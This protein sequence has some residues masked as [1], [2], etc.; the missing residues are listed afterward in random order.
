MGHLGRWL[1]ALVDDELDA[2]ERDRV[3]NHLAGCT[4]CRQ[5][6]NSLRALKR[7]M[8]S[9]SDAS[10]DSSITGRLIERARFDQEIFGTTTA[11]SARWPAS[12][13]RFT[14]GGSR[15]ISL[16]W[17][18]ATGS[19]GTA[20]VAIGVLAFLLGGAQTDPP[21]PKVTPAVDAY[22]LQHDYDTGQAPGARPEP[23]TQVQ[24][25]PT[26][27][28]SWAPALQVSHLL[29]PAAATPLVVA[30]AAA[31]PAAASPAAKAPAGTAPAGTAP[32][33]SPTAAAPSESPSPAPAPS[34]SRLSSPHSSP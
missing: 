20:L 33:A 34:T 17:R 28:G 26:G 15:Q 2:A 21:A 30:P 14:V 13:G 5:E 12:D 3:L 11:G 7:R 32:A 23:A 4:G 31:A 29:L 19:A 24:P 27:A 1:S 6:A 10:A 8:T 9:L 18:L 25:G 16:G 22:W